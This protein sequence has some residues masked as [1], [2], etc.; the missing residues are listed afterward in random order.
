A[1]FDPSSG[2]SRLVTERAARAEADQRRGR[3]GRVA[4]GLCLRLWTKG[5]E[6]GMPAFA[7][8]EI[9]T[10]D[11]APL[12]LDLA[13]WGARGA[14]GL[15][16][17]TPPAPGPLAEARAL[18]AALGA[19]D[20]S[21]AIT[22]HGRALAG[23]P[24][25]PRL[26]HMLLT[27]G[28][29]AAPL[30]ALLS[31]RDPLRGAPADLALRLKALADPRA[32]A[33]EHPWP[34]HRP[35][36]ERI[37]TEARRL[38]RLVPARGD[39]PAPAAMAAL[40]YPD[41]IG[42]RRP[43]SAPRWLLSGGKGAAMDPADPLAGA[44][45]IVATDLDGDPREARIRQAAALPEAALRALYPDRLEWRQLCE[46]SRRERR[47]L[48]RERE[49][50]GAIALQDRIWQ[51]APPEAVARAACDGLRALGLDATGR[52]P[53]FRRLQ[54]RAAVARAG[55]EGAGAEGAVPDI[56]D[57][58]L[59]ATLEDWL[60]P[61]LGACRT[62]ADLAALDPTEALRAHLGHAALARIE[63]L[64][65]GH[66]ETPL[67]RRLAIDY[68][69]AVPAASVRVQEVFGLTTHPTVGPDRRP[70]RLTLLAPGGQP[71]QVTTDLPGF[72]AG[73]WAEVR[74]EMRGRYPRHPWPENPAEAAPTTR[75]K[76]RGT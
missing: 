30:A 75:A 65:P 71:L 10:A 69:G 43:G 21:G 16:F 6:G 45:L 59:L 18:L 55:A 68:D 53:A 32:H 56:A 9:E 35:T 57:A 23:L 7:P 33:A 54:A 49:M 64:A 12:A 44:R 17:L 39:A 52:G 19:L 42:L 25:H 47:V 31:E 15:A 11:L 8:P 29:A 76:P 3:A 51:N 72:W 20:A 1:R 41:R 61:W 37:R 26:G 48:A 27:A 50:F 73:A 67:G 2:M 34:V 13:L 36:I 46:W 58:A 4:P 40:A 22:A 63:A 74:G 5:E 70:L 14:E 62:A 24:L 28:R 60:A 66:F 38:A